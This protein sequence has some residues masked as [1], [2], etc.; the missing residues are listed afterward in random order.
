M[1]QEFGCYSLSSIQNWL[2]LK[3][4]SLGLVSFFSFVITPIIHFL[5]D[6]GAREAISFYC[7]SLPNNIAAN[8][9]INYVSTFGFLFVHMYCFIR[10]LRFCLV[11]KESNMFEII[12]PFAMLAP[13]LYGAAHMRYLIPLIPFLLLMGCVPINKKLDL[14]P[15]VINEK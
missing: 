11:N 2:E 3:G 4:I 8:Q 14:Q 6:M 13:T 7:L 1:N 12:L 15:R 10:L 9:L 5:L